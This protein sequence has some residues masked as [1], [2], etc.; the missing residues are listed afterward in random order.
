MKRV[1]SCRAFIRRR[2]LLILAAALAIVAYAGAYLLLAT[3]DSGR[4]RGAGEY[5]HYRDFPH[6]WEVYL[7]A[8]AAF[9]EAMAIQ[10]NPRPFLPNPSW[11]DTQQRLVIRTP[12]NETQLWFPPFPKSKEETPQP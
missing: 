1:A 5:F 8:P 9:V 2:V 7:F 10:I 3:R 12:D 11:A 6:S 4:A